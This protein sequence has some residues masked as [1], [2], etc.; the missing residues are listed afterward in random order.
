MSLEHTR[1]CPTFATNPTSPAGAVH[2]SAAK[3]A[4]LQRPSYCTG[5][6]SGAWSRGWG[7]EMKLATIPLELSHAS[8]GQTAV[9]RAAPQLLPLPPPPCASQTTEQPVSLIINNCTRIFDCCGF[10]KF[11]ACVQSN[12][13]RMCVA[14]VLKNVILSCPA[15]LRTLLA[16]DTRKVYQDTGLIN[17]KQTDFRF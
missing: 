15:R 4:T 16:G 9:A 6:A 12:K 7:R 13:N 3:R 17:H 1:F 11:V 2:T 5:G 14:W 10:R 8:R